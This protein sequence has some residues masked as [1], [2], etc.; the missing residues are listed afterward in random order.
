MLLLPNA[1][2]EDHPEAPLVQNPERRASGSLVWR[3]PCRSRLGREFASG[4]LEMVERL[5]SLL[6][7]RNW[8]ILL[9][10]MEPKTPPLGQVTPH[11]RSR[12][13][14][15]LPIPTG[16]SHGLGWPPALAPRLSA[17]WISRGQSSFHDMH[18]Y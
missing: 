6:G 16:P 14:N 10:K 9:R 12:R 15:A 3:I 8:P 4:G 13:A 5:Q 17:K 7:E 18:R 1:K 2:S 11:P